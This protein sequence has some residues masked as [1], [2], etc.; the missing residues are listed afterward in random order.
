MSKVYLNSN[1]KE[2]RWAHEP[3]IERLNLLFE[4]ERDLD[5]YD[6]LKVEDKFYS[7]SI[8]EGK[9]GS[10]AVDEVNF[11]INPGSIE[12]D[13][14]ICPYCGYRD[15]DSFEYDEAGETFCSD[16]G[17]TLR[18]ERVGCDFNVYPVFPTS[19]IV[20]D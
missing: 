11:K 19:I 14:F 13:Y 2:M 3:M 16:C 9:T 1:D 15:D 20:I 5:V 12:N 8:K 10:V 6:I 4:T 7:V 18:Y 17:S